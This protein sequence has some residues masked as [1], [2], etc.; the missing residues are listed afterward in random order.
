M[1][2]FDY[3]QEGMLE[4]FVKH[5][6]PS[7][8]GAAATEYTYPTGET[9]KRD[10]RRADV[11]IFQFD[12]DALR[13]RQEVQNTPLNS[14]T[15]AS[16]IYDYVREKG[17]VPFQEIIEEFSL[18]GQY[19]GACG[20][21]FDIL[22]SEEYIEV[23]SDDNVRANERINT[24]NDVICMEL[25]RIR[26][27]EG[28]GQAARSLDVFANQAYVV[29]DATHKSRIESRIE[30]VREAGVGAL[31]LSEDGYE[32]IHPPT[33]YIDHDHPEHRDRFAYEALR[34]ERPSALRTNSPIVQSEYLN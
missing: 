9:D 27:A 21:G 29:V 20:G 23:D 26:P 31:A 7:Y 6:L 17:E 2:I 25:K 30:E 14:T 3:E 8:Q 33:R 19:Y 12:A 22:R 16:Q 24:L 34:T 5:I 28:I 11:V 18:A 4:P 32:L 1:P 13:K 15:H 10:S